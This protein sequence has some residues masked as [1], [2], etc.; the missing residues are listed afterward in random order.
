MAAAANPPTTPPTIPGRLSEEVELVEDGLV[1]EVL[2][3]ATC[4]V[5]DDAIVS[6]GAGVG[7][8]SAELQVSSV[9]VVDVDTVENVQTPPVLDCTLAKIVGVVDSNPVLIVL[10]DCVAYE[11]VPCSKV[12]GYGKV[13]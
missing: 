7:G 13:W 6:D 3:A 12:V 8:G 4:A 5:L 2:D 1:D 9:R 10:L 11:L